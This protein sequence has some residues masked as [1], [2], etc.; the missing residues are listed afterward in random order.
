MINN[1]V[2]ILNKKNLHIPK[3]NLANEVIVKTDKIN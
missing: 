2:I 3:V 1:L